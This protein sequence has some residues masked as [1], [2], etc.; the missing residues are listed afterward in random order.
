MLI[1][2]YDA[3]SATKAPTENHIVTRPA[4]NASIAKVDTKTISHITGY[5]IGKL[6]IITP[7]L[8]K[9]ISQNI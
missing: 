8:I 6:T 2:K 3:I 5:E 1:P 4:V 7:F 9:S